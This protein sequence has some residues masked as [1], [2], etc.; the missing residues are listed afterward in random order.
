MIW[1]LYKAYFS[2][3]KPLQMKTIPDIR[4]IE[5]ALFN[6]WDRD[7]GELSM[8]FMFPSLEEEKGQ[9]E[10][11]VGTGENAGMTT[12]EYEVF[13]KGSDIWI[14]FIDAR[15]GEIKPY[16]IVSLEKN[17]LLKLHAESGYDLT[18]HRSA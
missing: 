8:F 13:L 3:S 16:Q 17:Q 12:W 14:N 9:V 6:K 7:D 11:I 1:Q 5:N 4:Q 15:S 2:I 18:F 10:F